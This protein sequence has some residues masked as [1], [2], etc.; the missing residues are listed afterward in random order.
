[1]KWPLMWRGII[2]GICLNVIFI[3][4]LFSPLWIQTELSLPGI[5]GLV[6]ATFLL[7]ALSTT[8]VNFHVIDE[9]KTLKESSLWI[10]NEPLYNISSF[11]LTIAVSFFFLL[12]VVGSSFFYLF[13]V[14]ILFEFYFF[15]GFRAI[16]ERKKVRIIDSFLKGIKREK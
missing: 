5:I 1:M 14:M 11:I 10:L 12:V 8:F 15:K 16:K 3:I 6:I 4:L 9:G 2:L 7:F 13:A